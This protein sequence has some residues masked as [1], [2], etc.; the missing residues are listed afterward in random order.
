LNFF[1]PGSWGQYT[2]YNSVGPIAISDQT[3]EKGPPAPISQA[4]LNYRLKGLVNAVQPSLENNENED[5]N[6]PVKEYF[7]PIRDLLKQSARLYSELAKIRLQ[8]HFIDGEIVSIRTG[9]AQAEKDVSKITSILPSVKPPTSRAWMSHTERAGSDGTVQVAIS[10][11]GSGVTVEQSW[12][13]GNGS[14]T[15]TFVLTI[16]PYKDVGSVQLRPP[17]RSDDNRWTI[18]LQS[19]GNRFVEIL[20]SPERRNTT[21]VL[22]SVNYTSTNAFVYLAFFNSADAIDAYS[23]FL[24]HKQLG[25]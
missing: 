25:R 11:T 24:Y 18:H 10:E 6:S 9:F 3:F 4:D 23:Y 21:G 17:M 7:D 8:P 20:T 22:R 14:M 12:T 1:G 13:G 2:Y 15:G 16:I 19:T 5:P